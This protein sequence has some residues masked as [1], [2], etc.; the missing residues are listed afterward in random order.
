MSTNGMAGTIGVAIVGSG[1]ISHNHAAAIARLPR[2]KIVA[3]VDPVAAASRRLA[4]EIGAASGIAPAC[5]DTLGAALAGGGVDLV[6]ICTPSGTHADIAEEAL[7]A[8]RH[9]VIEKPLDA[10]L[11]R[12]RHIAQLAAQATARGQLCSVISQHRFD[13]ASVAVSQAIAAGRFGRVTSAVASVA[14]W[15]SQG[16]YDSAGWRGT[17]ELDGGGAT[18]NQG[19][20]TVD[21][22]LWFLG[23]PTEVFAHTGLLA[24]DQIEVEDVTVATLR[25]A[26][27]AL[28][29]VHATTAAYPGLAVRLQV[30]GSRGSAVIHDDQ[31]EY[32]HVAGLQVATSSDVAGLQAA[33]DPTADEPKEPANQADEVVAAVERRGTAKPAD[34]FV[35]GHVRQY[36]D[37]VTA[38]DRRSPPAVGVDQALLAMAVVRGIYLSA[39]LGRPIAVDEILDGT[40]DGVPVAGES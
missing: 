35:V 23:R 27:G 5:Y 3:V 37:I 24:H 18:M 30:H 20:H 19:I 6:V 32:F 33:A 28:A 36:Q 13:P 8:G 39:T 9:V 7:A 10:S 31:L 12:A 29:V 14:W 25:F 1:I 17:W 21:L 34:S 40:Y 38:I 15:R 16:Y 26:S 22:L 2:L 4:D 11:A